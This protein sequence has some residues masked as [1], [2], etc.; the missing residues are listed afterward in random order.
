MIDFVKHDVGV[1]IENAMHEHFQ[2][3]A[4]HVQDQTYTYSELYSRSDIIRNVINE[5]VTANN[6]D[7]K[8]VV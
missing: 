6:Q 5:V 3:D 2:C 4:I 1:N 7:R 8:S